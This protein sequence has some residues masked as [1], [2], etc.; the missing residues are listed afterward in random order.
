[1]DG[2]E[3]KRNSILFL[4]WVERSK[5]NY[6]NRGWEDRV[7]EFLLSILEEYKNT[8]ESLEFRNLVLVPLE[9]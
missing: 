6:N 2:K 5:I 3:K 9:E 8:F 1:M 7:K 4:H